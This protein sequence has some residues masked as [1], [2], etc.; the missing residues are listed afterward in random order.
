MLLAQGYSFLFSKT[1]AGS[2]QQLEC[3]N[4][5]RKLLNYGTLVSHPWLGRLSFLKS[6]V[7]GL[8]VDLL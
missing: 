2:R 5:A 8:V 1:M 7:I 3:C 4:V 6:G